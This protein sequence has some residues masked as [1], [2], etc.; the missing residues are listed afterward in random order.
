M[1]VKFRYVG[2]ADSGSEF[3]SCV[4]TDFSLYSVG[5]IEL[6]CYSYVLV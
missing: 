2:W 5:E 4:I 3:L 1:V 6:V